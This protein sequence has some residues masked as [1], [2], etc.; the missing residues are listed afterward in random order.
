MAKKN[1]N[2]NWLSFRIER[3]NY[4]T[5][6]SDVLRENV[7]QEDLVDTLMELRKNYPDSAIYEIYTVLVLK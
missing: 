2:P 4:Y 6:S 7:K 3:R 5:N 1:S